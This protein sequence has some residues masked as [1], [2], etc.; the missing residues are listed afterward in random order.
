MS[1]DEMAAN[2]AV[3]IIGGSETTATLL[4]A[5]TYYLATTPSA[6]AKLTHEI[7]STFNSEAEINFTSVQKLDYM[8]AVLNEALRMYPPVPA[9]GPRKIAPEG[10]T[11]LG[12]YVPG[13]VSIFPL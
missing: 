3:L 12:Q 6:M 10:D 7:R 13:G 8:L 1:F 5:A 11:I 9:G 2:A 4:S